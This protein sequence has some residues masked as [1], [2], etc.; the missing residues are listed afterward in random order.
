MA[1]KGTVSLAA[2][3]AALDV[4]LPGYKTTEGDHKWW[5]YPPGGGEPYRGLP[6]GEHGKRKPKKVQV[7]RGHVKRMA[8]QFEVLECVKGEIPGL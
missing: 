2:V 6:K 8:R 7:E 3:W 5:V 1:S 4:C